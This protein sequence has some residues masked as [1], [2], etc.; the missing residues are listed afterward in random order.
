MNTLITE[1]Q[2]ILLVG[3]VLVIVAVAIILEQRFKWAS[4]VGSFFI[5]IMGG[6]ILSNLNVIPH[7]SPAFGAIDGIIL[8]VALPMFLYKADIKAII[9]QSGKLFGL[10]HV[11]AIGS[12]VASII[13]GVFF[14]SRELVA[15]CL[16][17]LCAGQVGGTVNCVAVGK[18]IGIEEGFL[19]TYLV[20]DNFA[21]CF[22]VLILNVLHRSKFMKNLLPRP[23]TDRLEASVD[24]ETLLAEGKTITAGFWGGKEISLK[25]IALCLASAFTIVGIS[26]VIAGFIQ[27]L[28]LPTIINQLFGN[29]YMVLTI[30]TVIFATFFPKFLGNIKGSME[31]GNI[32]FLMW[33]T[34]VG[35]AGD[36]AE[37]LRSGVVI[38]LMCVFSFCVNLLICVIGAKVLK[39]TWEEVVAA[40]MASVGGPPTVA[41]VA[42]SFG[43]TNI[44]IP[45]MLVGLWGYVI[46]NYAGIIIANL[47]VL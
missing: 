28:G 2:S 42:G 21:F 43:W 18:I 39:C 9:K 30:I 23:E 20:A 44:I 47:F 7:S 40:N 38:L 34:T 8:L 45:G 37:M 15:K 29:V 14:S 3:V 13:M 5:C 19:D 16:P 27:S 25:D 4:F 11:A 26:Q 36:L 10:F 35:I 33:F 12:L 31:I 24:K 6:F 41:A 1:N 46:G 17:I 32:C 22:M